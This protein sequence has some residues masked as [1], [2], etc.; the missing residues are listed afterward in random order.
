MKTCSKC[1]TE[2]P[3]TLEYFPPNKHTKDGLTSHCRI[4]HSANTKNWQKENKEKVNEKY[5]NWYKKELSLNREKYNN[6]SK[7]W[8]KNHTDYNRIKVRAYNKRVRQAT[9]NNFE[10]RKQL[11]EI[12]KA[13]PPGYEIDHIIPL[14]GK[15]V[16][17][18]H[19]PWNLQYLTVEENRK[20]GNRI[21]L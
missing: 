10:I 19:V 6:F 20:K 3:A 18:L 4:C 1:K 5:R 9:L 13:C 14:N 12:Y 2:Y 11:Q 16:C 15:N 17:G 7:T 8:Y 21:T